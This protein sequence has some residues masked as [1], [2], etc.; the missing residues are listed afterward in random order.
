MIPVKQLPLP[1]RYSPRPLTALIMSAAY[2]WINA[3]LFDR[4][5]LSISTGTCLAS[6]GHLFPP[7][8][9]LVGTSVNNVDPDCRYSFSCWNLVAC[10]WRFWFQENAV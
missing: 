9:D 8:L 3:A 7:G 4:F 6:A 1:L 5:V 10:G 2:N